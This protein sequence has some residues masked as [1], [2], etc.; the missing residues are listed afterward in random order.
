MRIYAS[1][2]VLFVVAI[3]YLAWNGYD[4]SLA[5][6]GGVNV[7]NGIT[8]P[9][10]PGYE[11]T[12]RPTPA[13]L[14][15]VVDSNAKLASVVV[16]ANPPGEVAAT[17][18]VVA[19]ESMSEVDG[20]PE[21]LN[22]AYERGGLDALKRASEMALG[23]GFSDDFELTPEGLA[24]V[25]PSTVTMLNPDTIYRPTP[26]GQREV[27]Y[28]AGK[29][30]VPAGQAA[31]FLA[32]QS[33]GE[34]TYNRFNRAAVFWTAVAESVSKG[35]GGSTGASGAQGAGG[36]TPSGDG[37]TVSTS[38]SAVTNGAVGVNIGQVPGGAT[39]TP[40]T[41]PGAGDTVQVSGSSGPS[42][43]G[44]TGVEASNSASSSTPDSPPSTEDQSAATEAI[45]AAF[46][47]TVR[48]EAVP[49]IEIPLPN[50]SGPAVSIYQVDQ[51][52]LNEALPAM[53]P[54]PRSA[55]SGQR[56]GVKLLNGT[57]VD[58]AELL[59]A[60][61]VVAAGGEVKVVGNGSRMDLDTS[62]VVYGAEE[63]AELAKTI[64]AELG[65]TATSGE[66]KGAD[67]VV[68]VTVG[69]DRA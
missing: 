56:I 5:Q 30:Q 48:A 38:T 3:G 31:D 23:F 25:L 18:L 40:S 6:S 4:R 2:T 50:P 1:A 20:A 8:D 41:A 24:S 65:V 61:S 44:G 26:D 34:S 29:I 16:L 11:A 67:V 68:V 21:A 54:F 17:I 28:P 32:L 69:S 53:I 12:V 51:K 46:D 59:L 27:V 7:F 15:A 10:Q 14:V 49:L 45:T 62:T 63:G 39:P 35:I 60:G 9:E 58:G 47:G 33:E 66:V 42:Q 19:L 64:A 13:Y 52:S 36:A 22:T 43:S 55:V 57:T 37:S